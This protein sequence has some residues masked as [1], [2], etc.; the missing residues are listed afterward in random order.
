MTRPVDKI[1]GSV[2]PRSDTAVGP[3]TWRDPARPAGERVAD[4]LSR[5]TLAEKVAQLGSIWQGASVDGEGVAPMQD[6]FN[7]EQPPLDEL[8]KNGLGQLTR[9]FGTRPVPT[10]A[11]VRAM[12]GLQ[13]RI[14][15][16]SRFGIPAVAHEECLTGFAAWG[17]TIFPTP[18][19]WGASFDP[20]LVREMAAAFGATMR[21]VGVHQGL[22]PVLDVTRDYRWGRVEET[23]GEDPYL[24]GTVGTAYVQGLQSAGVQA[25]LKHF[26]A[27]SASR[28]ARNHAPVSMGPRELADVIL[29][30]FEMAIRI[31]GARSV[32][33]TYIDIDGV[34]ASADPRLLTRLLR[35]ELGF[36]G[37][38][39]SDYFAVSFIQLQ[40][41]IAADRAGAAALALAAGLD[42][43]LP[44][45]RCFGQP[46]LAAVTAGDI[47]EQLID[48][49]AA[50]VLRQKLDLGLL[51]PGWS[52]FPADG[53]P[54]ED[55]DLDLD[56]PEQR[57]IA[58][59]LAEESVVLVANDQGALPLP[60]ATK[61]AVIG[62]LADDPL[63][64]FGCYTMPRHLGHQA[65]FDSGSGSA[66]VEV[67]TVLAALRAEL[68][69]VSYARGCDVA[70]ADRSGFAEAVTTGRSAELIVAV[71]GDEAG[72]FGHGT[73]GEGCDVTDLNLP[74]VQQQLLHALADTGTPVVAVLVTGRPYALGDVAGRLAGVVQAFFP[75]EE[76]GRAIA[77]VLT[78]RVTPSGKLPVEIPRLP[79]AQPSTYLRSPNAALHPASD[80]D[81]TP[82][83]AFGH[84]L[85]YTT[86]GYEDLELSADHVPTDGGVGIS[87]T[88]R[89]TGSVAGAEVVQLYLSDPV[90]SVVRPV[91]WLAGF[92]RV[93]LAPGESA[94][95]TFRLHA[96]RTA[97]S[98]RDGT[99]IV[100]PGAI[101]VAVGGAS[102]DLPLAGSFTLT[103][104]V[105]GVD[106]SRVLTTP[107]SVRSLTGEDG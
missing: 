60:P 22:A 29:P 104:P 23:I 44:N 48:R 102:D 3:E 28:A 45:T 106:A 54:A 51:D 32:M 55:P 105:R 56:P 18:L 10:A 24:V 15:A 31:G 63:A 68:P 7:E 74:G 88:V 92:A 53:G 1:E 95:V 17:A 16:S 26:A 6:Q 40:H 8:I 96:D 72:L 35:D 78:G 99:R 73:S 101:T 33:P 70:T 79:G 5:M 75:G 82:L 13:A 89:N 90:A 103:G 46:L 12:A 84:G 97:F 42:V 14:V 52:P 2:L 77:G 34:P 76:G 87:C 81:P 69:D 67:A 11:G 19:A 27:Y 37:L 58:R 107:V 36:D 38:V 93:A 43:E 94:R 59:R 62:P 86:F 71:V 65:W 100:E 98:G 4:L 30:P 47:P 9:V 80:V 57:D 25:T 49:A 91:R 41:R 64:F 83:F 61:V 66:G 20:A 39:V 50:R 85:S 21:A